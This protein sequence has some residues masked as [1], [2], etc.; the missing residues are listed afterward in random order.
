M[1]LV[2]RNRWYESVLLLLICFTLFRPG[3]WLDRLQ[4]PFETRPAADIV[5]VAE[6]IPRGETVRF[7]AL[8]QSRAGDD[9]EKLVRL[10]LRTGESGRERLDKAGLVLNTAGDRLLIQTVRFGSEAARYGLAPGDEITA[11]LVPAPR[12]SRYWFAMPALA[13]LA[14]IVALQRRR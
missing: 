9:V 6:A 12:P 7:R 11:V 3:F 10:T 5:R 14:G 13:L 2:A 8:S 4:P 1:W